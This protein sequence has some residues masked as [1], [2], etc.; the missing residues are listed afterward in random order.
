MLRNEIALIKKPKS[1]PDRNLNDSLSSYHSATV[2]KKRQK[3]E[4]DFETV[5]SKVR[6]TKEV[7]TGT[8]TNPAVIKGVR[9]NPQ[10][11]VNYM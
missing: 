6:S 9:K 3:D 7:K 2:N 8:K 4:F 1:G 11:V 5:Q 10:S